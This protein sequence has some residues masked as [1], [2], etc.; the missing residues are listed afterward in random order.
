MIFD[1]NFTFLELKIQLDYDSRTTMK[2]FHENAI[3]FIDDHVKT[4]NPKKSPNEVRSNAENQPFFMYLAFRAPHAPH[5]HDLTDEEIADFLPYSILGK[6]TEQIGIFDRYIGNIMAKLKELEIAEN[7]MV[8][9]TSD[10]GPDS[11]SFKDFHKY[12]H[13][14]TSTMR[15]KKASGKFH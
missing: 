1:Q 9:F 8:I 2:L 4:K 12:G 6:P 7:T 3:S 10:N 5:S 13:I 15:G 11:S 14:R